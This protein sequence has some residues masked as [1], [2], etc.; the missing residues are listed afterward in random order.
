MFAIA[1]EFDWDVSF[2]GNTG[3]W[4]SVATYPPFKSQARPKQLLEIPDP[5]P[6]RNPR[7]VPLP[8]RHRHPLRVLQRHVPR[9]DRK[10]SV[11]RHPL[12]L[13]G[14]QPLLRPPPVLPAT[15][16]R[17]SI[18]VTPPLR[19]QPSDGT[20]DPLP[21]GPRP[22]VLRQADDAGFARQEALPRRAHADG[23]GRHGT[24]A[25]HHD[26]A[27]RVCLRG[28]LCLPTSRFPL[29]MDD[30]VFRGKEVGRQTHCGIIRG[31]AENIQCVRCTIHC[32]QCLGSSHLR[33]RPKISR[34]DFSVSYS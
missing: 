33:T 21:L 19:H 3:I 11:P 18:F 13:P 6:H 1:T 23:E 20:G 14:T 31:S 32:L 22:A 5:T 24:E 10:L 9:R 34:R 26:S 30:D 29:A 15:P 8:R 25:R 16:N 27:H 17:L 4:N 28:W 12:P 7:H 2:E